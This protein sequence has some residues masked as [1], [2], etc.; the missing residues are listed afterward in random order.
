[1]VKMKRQNSEPDEE[2]FLRSR[3]EA[4]K[5]HEAILAH[6]YPKR[7]TLSAW[8]EEIQEGSIHPPNPLT[9][10]RRYLTNQAFLKDSFKG[11]ALPGVFRPSNSSLTEET[12][13]QEYRKCVGHKP[14]SLVALN[15]WVFQTYK[16]TV[17]KFNKRLHSVERRGF[18][19]EF[20]AQMLPLKFSERED[21][22][23]GEDLKPH[24]VWDQAEANRYVEANPELLLPLQA[25]IAD[26]Q[27]TTI[28]PPEQHWD[29]YKGYCVSHPTM[30]GLLVAKVMFD[31]NAL[32]YKYFTENSKAGICAVCGGLLVLPHHVVALCYWWPEGL[33]PSK[34]ASSMI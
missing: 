19:R 33:E 32:S 3:Q 1:M 10:H 17:P 30:G 9:Y 8:A 21:Q 7:L 5:H 6:P 31:Y 2:E 28:G 25:Y 26:A 4:R 20:Y 22:S 23:E 13:V 15:Y 18:H 12:A 34:V 24:R 29:D 14:A 11:E 16:P 27:L